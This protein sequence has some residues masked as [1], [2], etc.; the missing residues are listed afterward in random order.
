MPSFA[1]IINPVSAADNSELHNLQKITFDSILRAKAFCGADLSVKIYT[2]QYQDA[3]ESIP[4]EFTILEDLSRTVASAYSFEKSRKLPMIKDILEI[5]NKNSNADY[6]IYTNLD[7]C[8]MPQ[9][10]SAINDFIKNG[11]DAFV[12]NKRRI[13]G[14][15]DSSSQLDL[16]YS[17]VGAVHTGY[18]TFVFSRKVYEKFILKDMCVGIPLA[19]NDLFYNI[20]CFAENPKLFTDQHLTF[21]IGMELVKE[22]GDADY[23][24]HNKKEFLSLIKEITP[25]INIAKFPGAE[26]NFFS[27][28]FKWLMNPT[29]HYPTM[30][31]ADMK[32]LNVERNPR[33]E[34][35]KRTFKQ[36]YLEKL[37]RYV[38][39]D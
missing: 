12:I 7:I 38:N 2:T 18:D 32:Q 1:H 22:W 3:R 19:G 39:F 8:L 31:S 34:K 28:H 15:Y 25:F 30:F 5:L 21:H 29:F 37:I 4:S 14:K 35:E 36:K 23:A 33:K 27:R 13:S 11:H 10:Y 6:F 17:E 9:F 20:F 24:A 16:M 26:L